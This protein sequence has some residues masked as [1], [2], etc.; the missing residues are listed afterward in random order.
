LIETSG[1]IT[2]ALDRDVA[3]GHDDAKIARGLMQRPGRSVRVWIPAGVPASST[4]KRD[5]RT[6][7][8]PECRDAGRSFA[9]PD[10]ASFV[11]R[12]R[13]RGRLI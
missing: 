4:T 11:D 5:R 1:G 6:G 10:P 8:D 3:R 13:D 12:D 9:G 2:R 7:H